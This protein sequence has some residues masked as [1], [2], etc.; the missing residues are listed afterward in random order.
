M[1]RTH[2]HK[3]GKS[4]STRPVFKRVPSWC[5]YRADEVEAL[6]VKL[7]KEGYSPSM[8]GQ[9]LRDQHGVPLVKAITDKSILQ[10]LRSHNLAPKTPEDLSNLLKKAERMV[11]HL[12][13]NRGDRMNIHNLQL[14]ESKI[15]RLSEYYKREGVLPPDWRYEPKVGSFL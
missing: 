7:A 8:I 6:V 11:R 5:K 12:E 14:L 15:H 3:R 9:I 4:H 13:K 10:I 2:S 1:A